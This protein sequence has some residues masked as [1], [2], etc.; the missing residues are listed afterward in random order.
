MTGTMHSANAAPAAPAERPVVAQF[1]DRLFSMGDYRDPDVD[2]EKL[3]QSQ[4]DFTKEYLADYFAKPGDAAIT[5]EEAVDVLFEEA[6][7]MVNEIVS[8]QVWDALKKPDAQPATKAST[9]E[10]LRETREQLR[11]L[12]VAH[13]TPSDAKNNARQQRTAPKGG[14]RQAPATNGGNQPKPSLWERAKGGVTSFSVSAKQTRAAYRHLKGAQ[15]AVNSAAPN[16]K[17]REAALLQQELAQKDFRNKAIRTT[18][19]VALSGMAVQMIAAQ[20]DVLIENFT[21]ANMVASGVLGG[22]YTT[23]ATHVEKRRMRKE[24]ATPNPTSATPQTS[25]KGEK[26]SIV[27]TARYI[28]MKT[29]HSD[30]SLRIQ[31]MVTNSLSMGIS[32][33]SEYFAPTTLDYKKLAK[34]DPSAQSKLD[35]LYLTYDKQRK[36]L[37]AMESQA[38]FDANADIYKALVEICGK[39][40]DQHQKFEAELTEKYPAREV[41]KRRVAVAAG[42]G[43]VAAGAALYVHKYG[44]GLPSGNRVGI[45]FGDMQDQGSEQIVRPRGVNKAAFDALTQEQQQEFVSNYNDLTASQKASFRVF[46][47]GVQH[48]SVQNP[49]ATPAELDRLVLNT[50]DLAAQRGQFVDQAE[51]GVGQVIRAAQFDANWAA[52]VESLENAS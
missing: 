23:G 21:P 11:G 36:S 10:M 48:I 43:I 6:A 25:P 28:S 46:A 32:K 37:K 5:P 26:L 24:Q 20:K 52:Y 7:V 33:V 38:D 39:S 42:L 31:T 16:S 29:R 13:V 44:V 50:I 17:E 47:D 3:F 8:T 9:D 27:D 34:D 15:K 18:G 41:S 2:P 14:N 12:F 30:V 40:R 22:L 19:A 45:R 35:S 51:T 4:A 1:R 49:N